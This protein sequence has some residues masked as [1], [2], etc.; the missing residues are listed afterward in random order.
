MAD[1]SDS[2]FEQS[3]TDFLT[4]LRNVRRL[5]DHTISNYRRDLGS[6]GDCLK[7]WGKSNPE[8]R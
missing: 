7:T 1:S 6:L 3:A 8:T 5:S 2:L 4:Y